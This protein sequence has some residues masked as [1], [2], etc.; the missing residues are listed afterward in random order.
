MTNKYAILGSD[1]EL[2][3]VDH[4]G[5]LRSAIGLIGGSKKHP[6]PVLD[7]P[8]FAV[9]EDNVALEFNIPP[10]KSR[11]DFINNLSVMLEFL[12]NEVRGLGLI[13][14]I[15]PSAYF[16]QEQL[17]SEQAKAFGC[18]A[19]FNAWTME[20]NPKPVCN[21]DTFRTCGGHVHFNTKLPV[22]QVVRAMDLFLGVPSVLLDTDTERRKL[23]GSA[24]CYRFTTYGGEY[25]TLSNFWL[26][27]QKLMGWCWDK[28][29]EAIQYTA[30]NVELD[31]DDFL[32]D[33]AELIQQCI[34]TSDRKLAKEL[35]NES[36]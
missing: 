3:L 34:N 4:F 30:D 35:M 15:K 21:D 29:Q 25:R 17:Q 32:I 22:V 27:D 23:Y 20:Q 9:Q 18:D 1:P 14:A 10:S 33:H 16:P 8:G 5:D 24:G 26:A 2:F 19:D 7:K 11:E 36:F 13:L 31:D 28:T 6:R 12:E